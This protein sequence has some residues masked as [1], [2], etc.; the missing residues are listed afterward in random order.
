VTRIAQSP[1]SVGLNGEPDRPEEPIIWND[2]LVLTSFDLV[3]G[4]SKVN[5]GHQ[6]P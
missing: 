1:D 5:T 3:T 2:T 6:L 4:P